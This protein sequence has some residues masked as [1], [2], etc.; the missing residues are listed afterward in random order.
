MPKACCCRLAWSLRSRSRPRL[1]HPGPPAKSAGCWVPPSAR[2]RVTQGV[3]GVRWGCGLSLQAGWTMARLV[4]ICPRVGWCGAGRWRQHHG[5]ANRALE[6]GPGARLTHGRNSA[7]DA[8]L[9]ACQTSNHPLA[10]VRRLGT[11]WHPVGASPAACNKTCCIRKGCVAWWVWVGQSRG[12]RVGAGCEWWHQCRQRQGH[13]HVFWRCRCGYAPR[14]TGLAGQ[15]QVGVLVL[16]CGPDASPLATLAG[17]RQHRSR[18][19]V[20][21][22]SP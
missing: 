5:G 22:S 1:T 20:G 9:Q 13:E 12:Q 4:V 11:H 3:P 15:R 19:L 18:H 2:P 6:C 17:G 7:D 8:M 16:G 21:G 14:P 10:S